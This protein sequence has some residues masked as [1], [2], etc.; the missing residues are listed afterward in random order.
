M[1]KLVIHKTNNYPYYEKAEE[2]F[3]TL[4]EAETRMNE[5]SKELMRKCR[6][7]TL[8][9]YSLEIRAAR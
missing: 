8:Q 9:N 3:R 1:Y 5:I 6:A 2:T 7:N 4:D